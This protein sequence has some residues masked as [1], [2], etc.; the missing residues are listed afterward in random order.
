VYYNDLGLRALFKPDWFPTKG[1]LLPR[2]VPTMR[3]LRIVTLGHV[4][5]RPKM[6]LERGI[7]PK[8]SRS[9]CACEYGLEGNRRA[10]RNGRASY[11][12]NEI[13][14]TLS[15]A[16]SP[17]APLLLHCQI[18]PYRHQGKGFDTVGQLPPVPVALLP[19]AAADGAEQSSPA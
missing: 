2:P 1:R 5:R 15:L 13:L 11:P 8:R 6:A 16:N 3:K 14:S 12:P 10:S 17:F 4:H 18:I 7:N 19:A 9:T